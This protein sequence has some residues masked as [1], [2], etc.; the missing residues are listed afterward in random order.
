ML[1]AYEPGIL[2][3]DFAEERGK[4]GPTPAEIRRAL[5]IRVERGG[6]GCDLE[7]YLDDWLHAKRELQ[8]KYNK[9]SGE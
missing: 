1:M 7:N 4:N 5:E 6:N 3:L 9:S 2:Q 8:E